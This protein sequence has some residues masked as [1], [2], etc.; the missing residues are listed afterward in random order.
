VRYKKCGIQERAT[1]YHQ[2]NPLT[3]LEATAKKPTQMSVKYAK[4]P[5]AI[6]GNQ[7]PWLGICAFCLSFKDKEKL[8]K[9]N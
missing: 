3:S 4:E 6:S 2:L 9:R 5:D 1:F 7:L 8:D